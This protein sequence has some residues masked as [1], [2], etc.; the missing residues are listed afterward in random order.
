MRN[1]SVYNEM[2]EELGKD[3]EWAGRM[4][5]DLERGNKAPGY[6][7]GG[8]LAGVALGEV[9]RAYRKRKS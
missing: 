7:A 6:I 9:F 2:G 4:L 8:I 5:Y 1:V 3:F